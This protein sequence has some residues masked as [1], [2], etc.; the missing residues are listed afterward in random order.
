MKKFIGRQ[1]ELK[2]L[3]QAY[4]SPDSVFIPVYGR[5]RVGKSELIIK[6]LNDKPGLYFL[7]KQAP[8][9]LQ[10]KEFL[11]EAAAALQEPLLAS[12]S[13]ANWKE[14]IESTTGRW[15]TSEKLILVFDEFQWTAA[16]SPELPSVIQELWDRKWRDAGNIMLILCGSYIGFMERAILGKK[17]PL[18]GRRTG[19]IF[20]KPFNYKEAAE[21]HPSFSLKA[22][23][24]TYFICGGIPLYLRYFSSDRSIEMNI[25][26]NFMNEF[27]PLFR[28]S[29]FLLREELRDLGNY[30]ALLMTVAQGYNT[31]NEISASSGIKRQSIHYYLTQL[32]EL[33]WLSRRYPLTEKS[34]VQRHVRWVLDDPILRFWFHFIFPNMS[35]VLQMSTERAFKD[36]IGP[37]LASYFGLCFERLC[38][39]ALP[40]IYEREGV[41]TSYKIGEYWDRRTQIDIV[42]LRDDGWTDLGEC[43]WGKLKSTTAPLDQLE[44][45]VK[46]YPN[47][48]N[49]TICRRVFTLNPMKKKNKFNCRFHSL[50]D[51][52]AE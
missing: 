33:G 8:A 14:A 24:E 45:K 19:Q 49:A 46:S 48:R 30:Y 13:T 7:G 47:E 32:S 35:Y 37:H 10:I 1:K 25:M 21:F 31:H 28:E 44:E 11:Q 15:K 36:R 16:S 9:E 52:Y 5:R 12:Y 51:M 39:E 20:L 42:G 18:F 22:V 41:K 26:D 40:V 3:K 4:D 23:A 6:F 27:A 29:D 43:K 38:R 34:P 17:S 2:M 50:E